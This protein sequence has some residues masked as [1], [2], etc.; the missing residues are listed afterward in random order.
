MPCSKLMIHEFLLN[1]LITARHMGRAG[2][3]SLSSGDHDECV[4]GRC[5]AILFN[6][7]KLWIE[8]RMYRC[9]SKAQDKD[10]I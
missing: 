4:R 6:I 7:I 2:S 8:W 9:G 5:D 1:L 3:C 10:N